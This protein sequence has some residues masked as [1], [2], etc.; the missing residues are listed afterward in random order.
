MYRLRGRC[1]LSAEPTPQTYVPMWVIFA[2]VSAAF[3]VLLHVGGV[4]NSLL[5]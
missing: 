4:F 1:S 3:I 5:Y 2:A